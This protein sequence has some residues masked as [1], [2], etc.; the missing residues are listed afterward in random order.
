MNDLDFDY[1]LHE[2]MKPLGPDT[3]TLVTGSRRR[4]VVLRLVGNDDTTGEPLYRADHR[5]DAPG[6][7]FRASDVASIDAETDTIVLRTKAGLR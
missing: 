1:L 2:M 6:I 3:V 4:R 5:D 7:Q